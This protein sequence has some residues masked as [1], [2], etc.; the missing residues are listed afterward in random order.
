MLS[1]SHQTKKVVFLLSHPIQYF[2]PLL[3]QLS[4]QPM[5]DLKVYYCSDHGVS[6]K[7]DKEFGKVVKWD[8][9]LLEGYE[10][11]FLPNNSLK[12][13][14]T[15]FFGL[16]N[17]RIASQVYKDK[18]AILIVHGWGYFTHWLS[19]IVARLLGIEVW[20][21]GETPQKQVLKKT[22]LKGLLQRIFT[23][24]ILFRC[25]RKFLYIGSQNKDFY[26]ALG[27]KEKDLVFTPYC[28]DNQRFSMSYQ[29]L[30]PQRQ[31]LRATLQIPQDYVTFLFCGKF[32]AKK[33]PLL[34]LEAYNAIQ[35]TNKALIMVGDGE[36]N[37]E[38]KEYIRTH[39]NCTNVHLVGFKNQSELP[40]YYVMA[41]V[42]V[43][44][45]TVGETWGLV[46]NEA[47]NFELP[48]IVSDM[49]GCA[50]DLV[51]NGKNGFTFQNEN[52]VDL[53]QKMTYCIENAST[54]KVAGQ[55][56]ANKIKAYS[57]EVIIKNIIN[58]LK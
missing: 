51:E 58:N 53:T 16:V 15:N 54:L 25:V 12:P 11:E 20:L 38:M 13:S 33:Q 52:A 6:N 31:S 30:I 22:F 57:Y 32:I 35:H 34:L 1:S 7:I 45:S 21:R 9:P 26:T 24:N 36:L 43:L 37:A 42:F 10:Y 39:P 47:M 18:P 44:P 19:I 41:D 23:K 28:I 50:D 8:I 40:N 2:S 14:V 56:S 4:S 27:I 49:V 46:V 5:I 48:L 55:Q 17:W 29:Q 3:Q